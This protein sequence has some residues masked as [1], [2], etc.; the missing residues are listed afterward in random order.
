MRRRYG[1]RHQGRRLRVVGADFAS[2][3]AVVA[4]IEKLLVGPTG[5]DI[6]A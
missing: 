6:D 2:I 4:Q 1:R 3:A 5:G